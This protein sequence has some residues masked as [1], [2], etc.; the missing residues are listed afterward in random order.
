[1]ILVVDDNLDACKPLC[2]LLE[3]DGY[4]AECILSGRE[5]LHSMHAR[6]P[7]LLILD[8]MM[9]GMSGLEVLETLRHDPDLKDLPV[10]MY[11]ADVSER[12]REQAIQ[13]GARDYLIKGQLS[14]QEL[15]ERIHYNYPA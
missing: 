3:M 13:L 6:K 15:R 12:D 4:E 1:M 8:I 14:W 11:T 5:A 9:P 10:V 7:D 2:R